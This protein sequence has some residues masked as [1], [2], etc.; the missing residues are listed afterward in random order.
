MK[1]YTAS[2]HPNNQPDISLGCIYGKNKK[3]AIKNAQ[4]NIWKGNFGDDCVSL[5][6]IDVEE[7]VRDR[8]LVFLDSIREE[9][10]KRLKA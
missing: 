9:S 10:L 7:Y 3:D 2:L 8:I 4:K 6:E 1:F 5:E